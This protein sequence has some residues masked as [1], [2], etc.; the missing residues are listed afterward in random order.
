M[1]GT[2]KRYIAYFTA[3]VVAL[4][5]YQYLTFDLT[6][7][8]A[9]AMTTEGLY[10]CLNPPGFFCIIFPIVFGW[11]I[12][13]RSKM[14]FSDIV[15][16]RYRKRTDYLWLLMQTALIQAFLF[17][18]IANAASFGLSLLLGCPI[19]VSVL[20]FYSLVQIVATVFFAFIALLYFLIVIVTKNNAA[21]F[22]GI[23]LYCIYDFMTFFL[24][25]DLFH[26]GWRRVVG[27]GTATPVFSSI[28]FFSGCFALLSVLVLIGISKIDFLN[29]ST[30]NE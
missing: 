21:A 19:T 9:A 26:I 25:Y 22:I 29:R 24:P 27:I 12:F 14:I 5:I 4:R 18:G 17:F 11:V 28:G 2:E 1:I 6:F 16:V 20:S 15:V 7:G 10:S 13:Q 30:E 23:A 8:N 3:A